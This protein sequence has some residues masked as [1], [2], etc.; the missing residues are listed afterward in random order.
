M[1]HCSISGHHRTKLPFPIT[2]GRQNNN[3]SKLYNVFEPLNMVCGLNLIT[4]FVV[5]LIAV[6]IVIPCSVSSA[7][8]EG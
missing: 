8:S 4:I 7:V 6:I 3:F 1:S 2:I 5:A